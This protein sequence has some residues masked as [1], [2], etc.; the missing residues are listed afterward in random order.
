MELCDNEGL[1]NFPQ[2]YFPSTIFFPSYWKI[3]LLIAIMEELPNSLS[4]AISSVKSKLKELS[5]RSI[6]ENEKKNRFK[7]H[8]S[9]AVIVLWRMVHI[10]DWKLKLFWELQYSLIDGQEAVNTWVLVFAET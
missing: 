5:F 7:L 9:D 10:R 8:H 3:G 1:K 4:F 6:F 2:N